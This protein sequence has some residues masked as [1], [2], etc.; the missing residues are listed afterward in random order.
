MAVRAALAVTGASREEEGQPGPAVMEQTPVSGPGCSAAALEPG[1]L[2][3][4]PIPSKQPV[5]TTPFSIP[6]SSQR[7]FS[8]H[9]FPSQLFHT[10]CHSHFAPPDSQQWVC[11]SWGAAPATAPRAPAALQLTFI[12]AR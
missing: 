8:Q 6:F 5:I 7:R 11:I 12:I 9:F 10:P 2:L 3:L 4:L 1:Q